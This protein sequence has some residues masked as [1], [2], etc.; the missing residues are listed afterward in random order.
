MK[1]TVC[2]LLAAMM[3]LC[4]ACA[5]AQT[6]V[7]DNGADAAAKLHLRQ[8]PDTSAAS[9]GRFYSGTQVEI[10][11][12]AGDG[13]AKV[14]VGGVTGYMK[15][16]F[17][18]TDGGAMDASVEMTVVSPYGTQSVV[19]RSRPSDS[20]DA[21]AML[22]VGSRVRVIGTAQGYLYVRLANGAA[23]CLAEDELK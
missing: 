22:A 11:E 6:A 3:L 2:F 10:L 5:L 4:C 19:V 7:V 23:G 16:S 8:K 18:R 21:V 15:S 14:A 12:D 1:K 9:L 20:Y 13:W 17:L